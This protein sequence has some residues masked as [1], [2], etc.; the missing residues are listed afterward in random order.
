MSKDISLKL[1]RKQ[2]K[3]LTSPAQEILYGGA[4][5][6]GKSYLLRVMAALACLEVDNLVVYIFRRMYKELLANHVYGPAGFLVMLKPLIDDKIVVYNKSEQ[7]FVFVDT[8]SRIF[9]AH[10]QYEDDVLS[11]LG[12]DFHMLLIDEASQWTEKMLR[13]LRSRVRL[14]ALEVPPEWKPRLPKIVYGTNP[15]GPAHGYLKKN[16]V[17]ISKDMDHT[18]FAPD[19]DGGMLRQFIPALY[20]DNLVQMQNDPNYH[21]RLKGMGEAETVKAYLT[22]D[23]NIREDAMFG[24]NLDPVIHYIEPFQIPGEWKIDRGYDH[25]QS[26]PASALW[27]AQSNGEELL[28]DGKVC[29]FPAGSIFVIDEKYFGT[30]D[31]KGLELE[32]Q[33]MAEQIRDHQIAHYLTRARPG[34]ADNSIFEAAPGYNSI[35]S[36]MGAVGIT[37][38]KSDKTKGSRKR[39]VAFI[40]QMLNAAKQRSPDRPH[41]YIFTTCPRLWGHLINLPRSE[42]DPDDVESVGT[43]DHDFDVLRYRALKAKSEAREIEVEGT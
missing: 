7:C 6:G 25:G 37:W 40:K 19:D 30:F 3:V 14:G 29:G 18:W 22:G 35:A 24:A 41:L 23:W 26:A 33:E 38:T 21:K 8:N 43:N 12:A 1:Y 16:F 11:Y 2:M 15:R 28:I 20:T 4:A 42:E 32:P 31:E 34:P 39:G 13:F 5:G 9:L 27:F 36:M 17:D 10:A